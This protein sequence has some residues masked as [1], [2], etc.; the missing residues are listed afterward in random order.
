[1]GKLVLIVHGSLAA[2]SSRKCRLP[3]LAKLGDNSEKCSH[4]CSHDRNRN[5]TN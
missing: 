5:F 3:L 4:I 1:M 2:I